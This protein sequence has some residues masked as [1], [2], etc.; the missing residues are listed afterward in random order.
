MSRRRS[1]ASCAS[2]LK[3]WSTQLFASRSEIGATFLSA[4][5]AANGLTPAEMRCTAISSV[6]F[7]APSWT[8]TMSAGS[9]SGTPPACH[10]ESPSFQVAARTARARRYL[11]EETRRW[12]THHRLSRY[13]SRDS[14]VHLSDGAASRTGNLRRFGKPRAIRLDSAKGWAPQA[15]PCFFRWSTGRG[16]RVVD[17]S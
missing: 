5:I 6:D 2:R 12:N 10:P 14:V 3:L 15:G 1:F 8:L 11:A 16:T 9:R 13:I 4:L 17:A 7:P